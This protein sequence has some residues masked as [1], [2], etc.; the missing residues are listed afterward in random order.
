MADHVWPGPRCAHCSKPRAEVETG[1]PCDGKEAGG[2]IYAAQCGSGV[3]DM[4]AN[5]V[6]DELPW[7]PGDVVEYR[8]FEPPEKYDRE[9]RGQYVWRFGTIETKIGP[10]TWRVR[11]PHG[12]ADRVES[13][14]MR[15][16]D[17]RCQHCGVAD[18]MAHEKW[19]KTQPQ[20][21]AVKPPLD[22]A[23]LV[24]LEG[25]RRRLDYTTADRDRLARDCEDANKRAKAHSATIAE[26]C[27]ERARLIKQTDEAKQAERNAL[28]ARDAIF[29][30]L[31]EFKK[32][33]MLD[34][35]NDDYGRLTPDHLRVHL[36]D[37]GDA[38]DKATRNIDVVRNA[39]QAWRNWSDEVAPP[40]G[41]PT[42]RSDDAQRKH[43]GDAVDSY[44]KFAG[45]H[46]PALLEYLDNMKIR[47]GLFW[48]ER[49]KELGAAYDKADAERVRLQKL[50][51]EYEALTVEF[52]G[53][54]DKAEVPTEDAGRQLSNPQ[55]IA[56]LA[57][58][59]EALVPLTQRLDRER[60]EAREIAKVAEREAIEYRE[61]LSTEEHKA[62][63]LAGQLAFERNAL[64]Q[65]A[66]MLED[67]TDRLTHCSKALDQLAPRVLEHVGFAADMP[68]W[69]RI[70]ILGRTFHNVLEDRDSWMRKQSEAV[71]AHANSVAAWLDAAGNLENGSPAGLRHYIATLKRNAETASDSIS[72]L[73]I[74]VVKLRKDLA[75]IG[76]LTAAGHEPPIVRV[77][78]LVDAMREL[79][80]MRDTF[81]EIAKMIGCYSTAPN[82]VMTKLQKLVEE[83]GQLRLADGTSRADLTKQIDEAHDR[84]NAHDVPLC[85]A[86]HKPMTLARRI[87]ELA[88]ERNDARRRANELAEEMTRDVDAGAIAEIGIGGQLPDK[89]DLEDEADPDDEREYP[90]DPELGAQVIEDV[91]DRA[92]EK[93]IARMM[94]DE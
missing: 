45:E 34:P 46:L 71:T 26:M 33:T 57:R 50:A 22:A 63:S 82:D 1:E 20:P 24:E 47:G 51:E 41:R 76:R 74:E 93:L 43:I 30:E 49:V 84:L 12:T 88:D 87:D 60:D 31:L 35:P 78:V 80:G 18:F 13:R 5:L 62:T 90:S 42:D 28:N 85:N 58:T 83:V 53:E 14:M 61:K 9:D 77:R 32:A 67:K 69:K 23:T 55:R 38:C 65:T 10:N 75:E 8:Y 59:R 52:I 72:R 54:L 27:D 89:T 56:L 70:D 68:M 94:G 19:C 40:W 15:R 16:A 66:A 92:A 37:L 36:Q 6:G 4:G 48:V 11:E 79:N 81:G 21:P 17:H 64:R 73:E 7:E 91:I 3:I 86:G 44:K 39:L 2:K 29:V 25:L